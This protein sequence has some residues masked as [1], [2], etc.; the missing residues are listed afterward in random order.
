MGALRSNERS[1][2]GRKEERKE[3][4]GEWMKHDYSLS[5]IPRT[6]MWLQLLG[7]EFQ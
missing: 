6:L 7:I 5:K 1:K 4:M 3:G 2:E